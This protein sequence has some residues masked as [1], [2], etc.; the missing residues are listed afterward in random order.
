VIGEVKIAAINTAKV[1]MLSEFILFYILDLKALAAVILTNRCF[2]VTLKKIDADSCC[3][4]RK[5]RKN[6]A[7]PTHSVSAKMMSLDRG[8][9]KNSEDQFQLICKFNEFFSNN[10][11]CK[12]LL[13]LTF[14]GF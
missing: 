10:F 12:W 2:L 9:A 3:R 7:I 13:K 14:S 5:Q 6:R 11:V 4:F 1:E 8:Y